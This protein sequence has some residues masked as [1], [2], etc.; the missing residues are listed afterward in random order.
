M[1]IDGIGGD[2]MSVFQKKKTTRSVSILGKTYTVDFGRDRLVGVFKEVQDGLEAMMVEDGEVQSTG[3]MQLQNMQEEEKKLLR[4]AIEKI[5]DFAS[6]EEPI[7]LHEESLLLYR[8]LYAYLTAV[9]IQVLQA[10][11]PYSIE[12]IAGYESFN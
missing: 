6:G 7:F 1:S 10:E 2:S 12:R 3:K 4:N 8:E 9:F 11:S 5:L